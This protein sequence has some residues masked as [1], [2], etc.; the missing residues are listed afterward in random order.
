MYRSLRICSGGGGYEAVPHPALRLDLDRVRRTL[1][2]EGIAVVDARVML[3]AATDP[4]ATISRSGR[5]LFKTRDAAAAT[6]AFE[7]LRALLGLPGTETAGE[8]GRA[9]G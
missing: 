5:I 1:E 2:A 7:R 6:R 9:T 8:R 3:L 4:E